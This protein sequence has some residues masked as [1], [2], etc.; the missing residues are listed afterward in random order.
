MIL[1][2]LTF[3]LGECDIEPDV[4]MPDVDLFKTL[5]LPAFKTDRDYSSSRFSAI[6]GFQLVAIKIGSINIPRQTFDKSIGN[7]TITFQNFGRQLG[8]RQ[9]DQTEILLQ[10]VDDRLFIQPFYTMNHL[11]S[12]WSEFE[13]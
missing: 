3:E 8:Q 12:G 6:A 1:T 2:A 7:C 5:S 10:R 4:V 13:I 9:Q 11:E